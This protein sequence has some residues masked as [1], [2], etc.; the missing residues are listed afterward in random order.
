METTKKE[1]LIKQPKLTLNVLVHAHL[2]LSACNHYNLVTTNVRPMCTFIS[3]IIFSACC[4]Y[5]KHVH[6]NY[7]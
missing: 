6:V 7:R 3:I 1:A 2:Q 4:D 5:I